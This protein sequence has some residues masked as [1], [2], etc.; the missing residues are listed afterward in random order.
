MFAQ[1]TNQTVNPHHAA[2]ATTDNESDN[3]VTGDSLEDAVRD[4]REHARGC[5]RDELKRDPTEDEINEWLRQQTEG[6]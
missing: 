3:A 5:L 1:Q 4:G 6:Y 2:N